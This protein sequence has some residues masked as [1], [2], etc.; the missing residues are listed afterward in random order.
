MFCPGYRGGLNLKDKIENSEL[1][2]LSGIREQGTKEGGGFV[3]LFV[4]ICSSEIQK[5]A[6][7]L[8]I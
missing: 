5:H 6:H 1:G 4:P 2:Y 3:S 8:Q 7:V